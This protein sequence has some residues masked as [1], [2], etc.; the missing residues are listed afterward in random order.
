LSSAHE[1]LRVV[2]IATLIFIA[3]FSTTT[4]PKT[5]Y[6]TA[7]SPQDYDALT[8]TAPPLSIEVRWDTWFLS[9]GEEESFQVVKDAVKIGNKLFL[10][11]WIQRPDG[12]VYAKITPVKEID[13]S[14]YWDG[15]EEIIRIDNYQYQIINAGVYD[16]T[17]GNLYVVGTAKMSPM[18]PSDI[19]IASIRA[20]NGEINWLK[21]YGTDRI[22]I[23][24]D[25]DI[26]NESLI[27]TGYSNHYSFPQL[28]AFIM[29][30]SKDNG[31]L[32]WSI[33]AHDPSG[34]GLRSHALALSQHENTLV[35]AGERIGES[36]TRGFI[37]ILHN[38]ELIG[39]YEM[40]LEESNYLYLN[41]V[42]FNET[43]HKVFTS[44]WVLFDG[45][46]HG[47]ATRVSPTGLE[48]G[49]IV[50]SISSGFSETRFYSV[51]DD[52]KELIYAG[53]VVDYETDRENMA[54]F[55]ISYDGNTNDQFVITAHGPTIGIRAYTDWSTDEHPYIVVG[56]YNH[57]PRP[58]GSA[59]Q[60]MAKITPHNIPS[61]CLWV[62]CGYRAPPL[63]VRSFPVSS[64]EGLMLEQITL[65]SLQSKLTTRDIPYTAS[66]IAPDFCFAQSISFGTTT[67]TTTF[68][69]TITTTWSTT[70]TV[71]STVEKIKY[72][73]FT[74]TA[75]ETLIHTKTVVKEPDSYTYYLILFGVLAGLGLALA[76]GCFITKKK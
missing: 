40:Y 52:G 58:S 7:G 11:G 17:S 60:A 57:L 63:Q 74:E 75:T 76:A 5:S 13:G 22:D 66:F 38:F 6:I 70:F 10:L 43:Q 25:I 32:A 51:S 26:F 12:V 53:S 41:D 62:T 19:F 67:H 45:R 64:S 54:V 16:E 14:L 30:V 21:L 59:N 29:S 24:E 4:L 61:T 8:I 18:Y 48:W 46:L 36:G 55:N 68:T 34:A 9:V 23:G 50:D 71:I 37:A 28:D 3:V 49:I 69:T 15:K 39:S 31:L 47:V 44:G 73:T 1:N 35:I 56:G 2:I 20:D 72:L 27:I 33:L 65:Q 42:T